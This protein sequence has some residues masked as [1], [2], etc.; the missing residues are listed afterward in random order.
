M[1]VDDLSVAGSDS[2]S[3]HHETAN[4]EEIP[5][6]AVKRLNLVP[7]HTKDL[8]EII[9]LMQIQTKDDSHSKFSRLISLASMISNYR[10]HLLGE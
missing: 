4:N 8:K 3:L 6:S 10:I 7:G 2:Q 9:T 5:S 1:E